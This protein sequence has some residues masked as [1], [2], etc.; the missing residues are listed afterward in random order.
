MTVIEKKLFRVLPG[1]FLIVDASDQEF[2]I[3]EATD[4]YLL[5]ANKGREIIGKPLFQIFPD[6]S[7]NQ[8]Q[9]SKK[10]KAS[11]EKIIATRQRDEW[12]VQRYDIS[13]AEGQPF[14]VR[15]WRPSN[16]P[17]TGED[18]EVQYIIHCVED[19]T[20]QTILG[21]KLRATDERVQQQIT[22]AISTTQELERMEIGRDLHD[23]INQLLLT[24]K[25]YL[26]RALQSTPV[27]IPFAEASYELITKAIEEIKKVSAALSETSFEEENLIASLEALIKQVMNDGS[28]AVE[29]NFVLPDESLIE[30]KVKATIFRIVQEQFS[31]IVKHAD[32]KKV[33]I[34]LGFAD[35]HLQLLIRDDGKGF[36]P[37]LRK[38]GMGFQNMKSRVA[39]M[40]GSLTINS[41]PGDGCTIE[42][43]IPHPIQ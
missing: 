4:A 28:I 43:N 12:E 13:I 22:D 35:N 27:S 19:V 38:Q 39:M 37:E 15:Y 30:G 42:I 25:L 17:V 41:S 9:G 2:R 32:A 14:E 31:N 8:N 16:I 21:Q 23:N 11:F 10:L 29:K 34:H 26:G 36:I 5:V 3:L 7:D 40:D 6:S 1:C 18:G 33:I 20:R 24:S